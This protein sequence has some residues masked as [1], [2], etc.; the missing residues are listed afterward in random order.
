MMRTRAR[1]QLSDGQGVVTKIITDR[2]RAR[3]NDTPNPQ[4]KPSHH[5]FAGALPWDELC[6][7]D[8]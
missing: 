7:G 2:C 5:D 6:C 4:V 3:P 1:Q 8:S